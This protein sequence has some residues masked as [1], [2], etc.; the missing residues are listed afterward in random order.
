VA[1]HCRTVF[2]FETFTSTA[3]ALHH[4]GALCH[5]EIF[6]SER[7]GEIDEQ[8]QSRSVHG[9]ANGSE[10]GP[11]F[12]SG[13]DG[14][15]YTFTA[16]RLDLLRHQAGWATLGP[17]RNRLESVAAMV[18]AGLNFIFV[19]LETSF[20]ACCASGDDLRLVDGLPVRSLRTYSLPLSSR[21]NHRPRSR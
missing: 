14:T 16:S 7:T 13:R 19:L 10:A 15:R 1:G 6:R 17:E 12:A 4:V 11:R 8:S 20:V 2:F 21:A 18:T 9:Q 5:D 3:A